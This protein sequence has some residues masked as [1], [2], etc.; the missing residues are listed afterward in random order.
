MFDSSLSKTLKE[1]IVGRGLEID[2][3]ISALASGKHIL[4]EGPP[5]T[6]KTTILQ[7]I[8]DEVKIPI[9]FL[10][11]NSDLT[12]T[13]LIGHFDPPKV[14]SEGY[15]KDNFIS[16]PLVK[17]MEEGGILYIEEFNRVPEDALNS[18]ITAMSEGELP[19]PR[20]GTIS[21]K[22]NFRIVAAMNPFDDIGVGRISRAISDRF[23]SLRLHYQAK[24]EEIQIVQR[25]TGISDDW[26]I[27]F[28]VDVVRRTREHSDLRMGASVRGAID[29]VL[30]AKNLGKMGYEGLELLKYSAIAALR[31]KIWLREISG[32]SVDEIISEIVLEVFSEKTGLKIKKGE[33]VEID[34][35]ELKNLAKKSRRELIEAAKGIQGEVAEAVLRGNREAVEVSKI[36]WDKLN[37]ET[38]KKIARHLSKA[39]VKEAKQ[40]SVSGSK[41]KTSV[42]R[43]QF[44]SD[45]LCLDSTIDKSSVKI[46]TKLLEYEDI[47]VFRKEKARKSIVVMLDRSGSMIGEKIFLA[48]TIAASIALGSREHEFALL[49][50][51]EEVEFIKKM[52]EAKSVENI[53]ESVL[54]L[55]PYGCTDIAKALEEGF[56]ELMKSKEKDKIGIILT[57]GMY[58]VG[59][60]PA[61]KSKLFPKLV[62]L[63][64][65]KGD[66]RICENLAKLGKGEVIKLKD[67][68][69]S[70][71][72]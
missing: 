37:D 29:M 71:T 6:S 61:E 43:Y 51:S 3:I 16:G 57:D 56:K 66:F 55:K 5:G 60:D 10:T 65:P 33:S 28:A 45:E 8:R 13:K 15:T 47:Q 46:L 18:L 21:A 22:G 53:V 39:I 1:K 34:F 30:I 14:L 4:L 32:R 11:G 48:A 50:F 68:S 69:V 19:I 49:A 17:A 25:R 27:E 59:E 35:S 44:D 63:C 64:P 7:A 20:L 9:F 12:A 41:L 42:G 36:V 24:E 62:V 31:S 52:N 23:C 2:L 58:N 54:L 67:E 26:L 40:L 70:I 72:I 38:K